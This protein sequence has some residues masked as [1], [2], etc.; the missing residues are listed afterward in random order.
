MTA[1]KTRAEIRAAATR[2]LDAARVVDGHAKLLAGHAA[3]A[4]R[5][6]EC[7]HTR[8][9]H[10]DHVSIAEMARR[11]NGYHRLYQS[12]LDGLADAVEAL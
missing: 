1:A 11:L 3:E 2:A 7:P 4:A 12:S 10:C 8:P 5:V 9:E 6:A